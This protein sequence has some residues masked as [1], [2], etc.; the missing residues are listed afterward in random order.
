MR[1]R[2]KTRLVALGIGLVVGLVS[3]EVVARIWWWSHP[4]EIHEYA[5]DNPNYT[6]TRLVSGP[7]RYEYTPGAA[8]YDLVVNSL[9]FR[10]REYEAEKPPGTYRILVVGDSIVLG[11]S[12]SDLVAMDRVMANVMED[13]LNKVA[14]GTRYEVFSTG[15]AGYNVVQQVAFLERR[16]LGFDPD[17]VVVGVCLNDFAPAQE[18]RRRGD[19]WQVGFYDEFFPASLPL[20]PLARPTLEYVF[21]SRYLARSLG[22]LGFGAGKEVINLD[23]DRTEE[24]LRRL[25]A[26]QQQVPIVVAVFPFLV[27]GY[28]HVETDVEHRMIIEDY[29]AAGFQPIDLVEEFEAIPVEELKADPDD[30][31]HPNDLGHYLAA[32]AVLRHLG[33]TG[34]LPDAH[35]ATAL[36]ALDGAEQPSAVEQ[37]R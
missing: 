5:L 23:D 17:L 25:T 3:A 15:V 35:A 20:G 13:T 30:H 8:Q 31:V 32:L 29:R 26:M 12:A 10:D 1:S 11:D 27:P 4:T 19:V 2:W 6:L 22:E 33:Q 28:T 18:V 16:G 24:A 34:L 14:A 7:Q 37:P 36:L 9:G 21:F